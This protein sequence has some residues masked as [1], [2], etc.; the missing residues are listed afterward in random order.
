M[1]QDDS[2]NTWLQGWCV[3][4]GV[5]YRY[6]NYGLDCTADAVYTNLHLCLVEGDSVYVIPTK[7]SDRDDIETV[8]GDGIDYRCSDFTAKIPKKQTHLLTE[9]NLGIIMTA[10]DGEELLYEI[11]D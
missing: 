5:T 9:D 3:R 2:G 10:P 7:L 6:Y 8:I 11:S 4:K 1:T